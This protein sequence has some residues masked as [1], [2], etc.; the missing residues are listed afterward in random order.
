MSRHIE[1][2][3]QRQ[4]VAWFRLQYPR[5]ALLLV[6]NAN[7]GKRSPIEAAIMKGE[8]VTAGVSDLTLYLPNEEY[9]GLLIEM[10][11]AKG[12]QSEHQKLWQREVEKAGY[13]YVVCR[14]LDDFQTT[15]REYV[16]KNCK[17]RLME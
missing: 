5:Y 9:H 7:G 17:K 8:G 1:S 10:K 4:C 15:I 16:K 2:S 14:S 3:I 6:A 13:K 12:R 11:T